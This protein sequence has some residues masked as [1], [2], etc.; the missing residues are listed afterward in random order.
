MKSGSVCV[1]GLLCFFYKLL[2][3]KTV[4]TLKYFSNKE[5]NYYWLLLEK[6]SWQP[7]HCNV[8]YIFQPIKYGL[9]RPAIGHLYWLSKE[10]ISVF[11]MRIKYLSNGIGLRNYY[12][13][14]HN[15]VFLIQLLSGKA[16][17]T[18]QVYNSILY[19]CILLLQK[20]QLSAHSRSIFITTQNWIVY[21]ISVLP[22]L[23]KMAGIQLI[24]LQKK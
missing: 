8:V 7:V 3:I 21:F 11:Y 12:I 20:S 22:D 4:V 13:K 1:Q 6:H 10:K 5:L 15:P 2:I 17:V 24:F 23:N 18:H 9:V 16:S 19:M 14:Q